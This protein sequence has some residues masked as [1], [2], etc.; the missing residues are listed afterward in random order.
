MGRV[1]HAPIPSAFHD[2][3][4]SAQRALRARPTGSPLHDN[5]DTEEHQ[6][7]GCRK[8]K[9]HLLRDAQRRPGIQVRVCSI[10]NVPGTMPI[11]LQLYS[12]PPA[13]PAR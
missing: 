3:L 4:E 1:A 11:D 13:V 9:F 12:L 8:A 10:T 6:P 2:P 5:Q 7:S